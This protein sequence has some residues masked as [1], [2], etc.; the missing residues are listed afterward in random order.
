MRFYLTYQFSEHGGGEWNKTEKSTKEAPNLR[1]IGD[2]LDIEEVVWN[3]GDISVM[4]LMLF[5]IT[6]EE[7]DGISVC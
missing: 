7:N 6:L 1:A 5:C 2:R 4:L 3:V